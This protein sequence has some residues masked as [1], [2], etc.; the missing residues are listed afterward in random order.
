M[1]DDCDAEKLALG[2]A[3][4]GAVLLLCVFHVLK[5]LWTWIWEAKH[6]IE[7]KDRQILLI[8]FRNVLYT[9]TETELSEKLEEIYADATVNKYPQFHH[10]LQKRTFPK[11]KAWSVQRRISESLPTSS[12]NTT[13]LVESSFRYVKDIMFTR[14]RA[15]NLSEML[16][17]VLDRS[18]WYVNKVIDAANGRI[19]SWLRNCH[20]RYVIK[21]PDIDEDKIV[22]LGPS[23]SNTYLVPSE[24]ALDTSYV[25]DMDTRRCTCPQGRLAGPCKHKVLIAHKK[26]VP[27]FAVIPTNSPKMTELFVWWTLT[28]L[29]RWSLGSA[30]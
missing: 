6:K 13:N 10:H 30:G 29:S 14:L 28:H 24:T 8:L 11:I 22:Q 21:V 15:F 23:T 2:H 26:H 27:S 12:N 7:H 17:I 9:E 25:V 1:T 19:E 5:A 18:E 16:S 20:S 4:P 3:W